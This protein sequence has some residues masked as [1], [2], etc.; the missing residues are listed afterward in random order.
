MTEEA[1]N[2]LWGIFGGFAGLA[3]AVH[4][5]SIQGMRADFWVSF[6]L[7]LT[8]VWFLVG[9]TRFWTESFGVALVD[10]LANFA[11]GIWVRANLPSTASDEEAMLAGA[12]LA[13]GPFFF[14]LVTKRSIR[15]YEECAL[16]AAS[17]LSF[18]FRLCF[19]TSL[20]RLRGPT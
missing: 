6:Y 5:T 11:L 13:I 1:R 14:I 7:M 12:V 17:N 16:F 2:R 9:L 3:I 18:L 4:A 20:G 8:L 19:R 10:C 15:V